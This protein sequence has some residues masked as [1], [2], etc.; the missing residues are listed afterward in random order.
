MRAKG[1]AVLVSLV[2]F[3]GLIGCEGEPRADAPGEEAQIDHG[4]FGDPYQVVTNFSPSDPD[5]YPMLSS[6]TLTVRL[7]Y[8]GGCESHDLDLRHE[9]SGDTAFVWIRHDANGDECEALIS[10]ELQTVL[11]ERIHSAPVVALRHPGG[12]PLQILASR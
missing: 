2:L 7:Q 3:T 8:S 6:D 9:V 10:D 5:L 4:T 12:G 11:P 1:K